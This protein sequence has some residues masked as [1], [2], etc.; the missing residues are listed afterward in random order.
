MKLTLYTLTGKPSSTTVSDGL[1]P[2]EFNLDLVA[3]AIHVY[4]SNLRQG[5]AKTLRRGEVA[6]T[7]AKMYRQKGTGRARHGAAS[8]PI[9]VGGGVAHGPTGN[10]N[11]KKSL[12]KKMA[13]A[14]VVYALAAQAQKNNVAIIS[15]LDTI[16][17]KVKDGQAFI[18]QT[19]S[20]VGKR[21]LIVANDSHD[22]VLRSFGNVENVS[23][24]RADRL[25]AYEVALADLVLI[26]EPALEVLETRLLTGKAVKVAEVAPQAEA[27]KP[28]K[29]SATAPKKAKAVKKAE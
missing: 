26:M 6:L 1:F 11:F 19:L 17:G 5:G 23:V 7:G 14:A 18:Q 22:V 25:N 12:P 27:K 20:A 24:T 8:A 16:S 29:K 9:F 4:R 2:A 10:E 28:A 3:Q 21:I 13:R 15:G